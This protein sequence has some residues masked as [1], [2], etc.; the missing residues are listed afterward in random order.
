MEPGSCSPCLQKLTTFLSLAP[1][2]SNAHTRIQ[3][4]LGSFSY[5][6]SIYSHVT[7]LVLFL[8]IF[9]IHF[10]TYQSL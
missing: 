7:Y 9:E 2:E 1:H 5:Y 10:Y 6:Q 4:L 8:Q 3:F